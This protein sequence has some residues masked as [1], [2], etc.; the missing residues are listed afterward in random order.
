[1]K[2]RFFGV[3]IAILMVM[4]FVLSAC[5][6]IGGEVY[7]LQEA[8]D[9]GYLSTEN[10]EQIAYYVNNGLACPQ[11]LESRIEDAIKEAM[12][13]R[14]RNRELAPCLDATAEGITIVKY[15]GKYSDS[16]VV[17][18]RNDY[19]DHPADIPNYWIEI[20]GVQFHIRSYDD[21]MLWRAK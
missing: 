10:L 13:Y 16:F 14:I 8:F 11:T 18:L 15:Y 4:L 1:M 9:F 6:E 17:R 5:G 20:G 7:T 2:K 21:I 19:D 12:A 3:V